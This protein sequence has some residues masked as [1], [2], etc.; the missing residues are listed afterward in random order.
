MHL[1]FLLFFED[2]PLIPQSLG[3]QQSISVSS[4]RYSF[5][6]FSPRSITKHFSFFLQIKKRRGSCH[7]RWMDTKEEKKQ[8]VEQIQWEESPRGG[9]LVNLTLLKSNLEPINRSLFGFELQ[10]LLSYIPL[11][12]NFILEHSLQNSVLRNEPWRIKTEKDTNGNLKWFVSFSSVLNLCKL[13]DLEAHHKI[14]V[15]RDWKEK[16]AQ[17][18]QS[19][20]KP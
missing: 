1:F 11:A 9:Y 3:K 18:I 19:E 2:A 16:V 14:R 10:Q 12:S 4:S 17:L 20:E 7:C 5:L 13:G 6:L 8:S 15:S